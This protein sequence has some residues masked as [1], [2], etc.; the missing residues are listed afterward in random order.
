MDHD[1]KLYEKILDTPGFAYC[2]NELVKKAIE[3]DKLSKP[4]KESLGSHMLR[5]D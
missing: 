1:I 4:T 3:F 5:R 2:F